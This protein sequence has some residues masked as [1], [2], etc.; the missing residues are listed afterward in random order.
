MNWHELINKMNDNFPGGGGDM[1]QRKFQPILS[2]VLNEFP[3]N[4]IEVGAL[5]GNS[6][7]LFCE[8]AR[9]FKRKVF[10]FDPWN[11]VEC[12]SEEVYKR[13]LENTA[14]YSDVLS[15]LRERSDHPRVCDILLANSPI[16]FAYIDAEHTAAAVFWDFYMVSRFKPPLICVDDLCRKDVAWG[17]HNALEVCK[18]YETTF[19]SP[20]QYEAY[21]ALR[22]LK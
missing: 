4:I 21:Y 16:A 12:G 3:G 7:V 6:T 18:E 1:R 20:N 8:M 2:R 11:G 9:E 10:T 15:T 13:Y 14:Q 22:G 5:H 17:I 19:E